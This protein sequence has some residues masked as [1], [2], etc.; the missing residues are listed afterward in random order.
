VRVGGKLG[1]ARPQAAVGD[2]AARALWILFIHIVFVAAWLGW[3]LVDGVFK[4]AAQQGAQARRL[5]SRAHWRTD[6]AVEIAAFLGALAIGGYLFS[7]G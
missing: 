2:S 5:I 7:A 4:R 6:Q 1:V 3:V